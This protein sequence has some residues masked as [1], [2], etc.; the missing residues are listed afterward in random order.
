MAESGQREAS[1]WTPERGACFITIH[2]YL[3]KIHLLIHDIIHAIDI[4]YCPRHP[5]NSCS[6]ENVFMMYP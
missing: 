1:G 6:Q 4:L 5:I 2:L 3:A